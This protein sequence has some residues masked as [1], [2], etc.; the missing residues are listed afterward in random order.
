[1]RTILLVD[2]LTVHLSKYPLIIC[3]FRNHEVGEAGDGVDVGLHFVFQ[4]VSGDVQ[5]MTQ[6]IRL[7]IME[8][9]YQKCLDIS[10]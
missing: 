4:P 3:R 7:K 6:G 8:L 5:N 10:E 9:F 2:S 1:M